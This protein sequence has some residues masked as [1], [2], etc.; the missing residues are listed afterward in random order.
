MTW[1]EW[2]S[3]KHGDKIK[4]QNGDVEIIYE[5][6]GEKYIDGEKSLFPLSEFNH[7]EWEILKAQEGAIQ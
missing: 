5:W 4:H 3:L 7:K 2:E 6:D 1:K